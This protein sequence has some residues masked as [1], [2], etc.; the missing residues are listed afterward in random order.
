MTS[1]GDSRSDDVETVF[2]GFIQLDDRE[3]EKFLAQIAEYRDE[4][5]IRKR[6]ISENVE[7]R[8]NRI[9]AGPTP[10]GCPCCGR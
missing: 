10:D 6:E 8:V 5:F 4:D 2:N 1:R 3:Q 7:K 9:Y